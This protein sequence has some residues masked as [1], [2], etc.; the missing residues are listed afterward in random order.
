MS[1][2]YHICEKMH[3]RRL[4]SD[5]VYDKVI[6]LLTV[7][8]LSILTSGVA[9]LTC[10][11]YRSVVP[12][13]SALI[14]TSVFF[15]LFA[16]LSHFE[17]SFTVCMYRLVHMS[18]YVC[19]VISLLSPLHRFQVLNSGHQ[20]CVASAFACWAIWPFVLKDR[21]TDQDLGKLYVI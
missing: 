20:D 12:G 18:W 16:R 9:A 17:L 14:L 6:L 8:G 5:S 13:S 7:W 19:G 3:F 10:V 2:I 15:C 4:F 1:L 21:H 11:Y